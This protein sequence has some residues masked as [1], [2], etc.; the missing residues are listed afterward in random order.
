MRKWFPSE[1]TW[2]LYVVLQVAALIASTFIVLAILIDGK[3]LK[4]Q[5][6]Y[7]DVEVDPAEVEA[8]CA[9]EPETAI[10]RWLDRDP[11]AR[12]QACIERERKGIVGEEFVGIHREAQTVVVILLV[13]VFVVP[14]AVVR[15]PTWLWEGWR[16]S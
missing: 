4:Y 5:P 10:D 1:F 2:R 15:V 9:S 6:V 7:E 3:F 14:F 8:K 11:A 16:K 12:L 13:L